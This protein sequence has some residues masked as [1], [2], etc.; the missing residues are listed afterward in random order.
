MGARVWIPKTFVASKYREIAGLRNGG[1][2]PRPAVDRTSFHGDWQYQ[3]EQAI[4]GSRPNERSGVLQYNAN[5]ILSTILALAISALAAGCSPE[6]G[7]DAW[8]EN[9]AEKPKGDWTVNEAAD[10]ARHCLFR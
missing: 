4:S 10:Y 7:S 2:R 9:M 5:R 1:L 6:V 3:D 8:C